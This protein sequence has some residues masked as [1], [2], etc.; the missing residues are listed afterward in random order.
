M[1]IVLDVQKYEDNVSTQQT[2]AVGATLR[3]YD[4]YIRVMSDEWALATMA[5]Y[6]DDAAGKIK[7]MTWC[8]AGTKV[9]ATPE[10]LE[11]VE[12]F[13]YENALQEAIEKAKDEALLIGKGDTVKVVKGRQG[14]GV[15]G[16]VVVQIQRAYGMG[17]K[18]EMR[19]KV[20]IATSEEKIM[21]PA[22]NGKVYENYKDITWAWA[23]NCELVE[24]PEI[25]MESVKERAQNACES[26]FLAFKKA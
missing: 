3:V 13:L 19:T 26:K 24:V 11:K 4:D 16:K 1:A 23:M 25:D 14:K 10:V 9:D 21:V 6:W 15:T 2:F 12:K 22:A 18:S 17:W 5:T 7:T 20:G 8:K